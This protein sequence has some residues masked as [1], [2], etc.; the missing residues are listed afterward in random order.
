MRY[1]FHISYGANIIR[2]GKGA[3]Y[4]SLASAGFNAHPGPRT[5][6]TGRL[7]WIQHRR[8]DSPGKRS[9]ESFGREPAADALARA[10]TATFST[11]LEVDSLQRSHHSVSMVNA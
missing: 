1:F 5:A 3:D 10:R 11:S 4:A 8:W 2:D 9:S 7:E 6:T